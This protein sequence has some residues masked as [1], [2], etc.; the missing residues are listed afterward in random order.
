[1]ALLGRIA[2]IIVRDVGVPLIVDWISS[3]K[4]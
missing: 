4:K 3:R 2:W 1:M